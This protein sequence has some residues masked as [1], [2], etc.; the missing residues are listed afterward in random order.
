MGSVHFQRFR[1]E[2]VASFAQDNV[3]AMRWA[4][5]GALDRSTAEFDRLLGGGLATP[6]HHL[7]EIMDR[8]GGATVGSLWF[9]VSSSPPDRAA[10][11]YNIRVRPEYRGRGHA[12]AAIRIFEKLVTELGASTVALHVFGFNTTAQALYRSLGYGITGFQMIKRLR[13]GA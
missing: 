13:P 7:Y 1:S 12:S 6:H 9:M 11:L 2:A 8:A 3:S 10:Y 4:E 5:D